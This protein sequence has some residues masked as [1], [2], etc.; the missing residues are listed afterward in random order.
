MPH[1]A[2]VGRLC[3]HSVLSPT[4]RAGYH[5]RAA[6]FLHGCT[7]F[8]ARL[9]PGSRTL[10]SRGSPSMS[11]S[12]VASER[13]ELFLHT[14][15]GFAVG[16]ER[17]VRRV[18]GSGPSADPLREE[19]RQTLLEVARLEEGGRL[20]LRKS[21]E[22]WIRT[23]Q[24]QAR[25]GR[26]DRGRAPAGIRTSAYSSDARGHSEIFAVRPYSGGT[27]GR[28]DFAGL[29]CLELTRGR[30]ARAALSAVSSPWRRR[31]VR[32]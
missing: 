32:S 16:K 3:R 11:A 22:T 19:L 17:A 30:T 26:E 21:A 14:R 12:A 10:P 29:A 18:S 31:N 4:E 25:A 27:T 23:D 28:A 6:R 15:V 13:S 7:V 9:F 1:R 8:L 24:G 20:A 5:E 2:S